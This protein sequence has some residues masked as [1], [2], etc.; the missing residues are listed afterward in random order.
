MLCENPRFYDNNGVQTSKLHLKQ[1][2]WPG[3]P[4]MKTRRRLATWIF[5]STD[6]HGRQRT[7]AS[8]EKVKLAVTPGRDRVRAAKMWGGL[9]IGLC[10]CFCLHVC[11]ALNALVVGA[12]PCSAPLCGSNVVTRS[13]DMDTGAGSEPVQQIPKQIWMFWHDGFEN[14]KEEARLSHMSW[15]RMNPTY[16][17]HALNSSEAERL[18]ERSK[19]V[20][21]EVWRRLR[22]QHKADI[23]RTLLVH[24]YGGVWADA[25]TFCGQPLDTWLPKLN[26][27]D[28]IT[29]LRSDDPDQQE[30]LDIAPWPTNW[31]LAAQ[32]GSYTIGR[33]VDIIADPSEQHRFF[34]EYFW[35]HRAFSELGR[36]DARIQAQ[37]MTYLSGNPMHCRAYRFWEAAP[38]FKR[39]NWIGERGMLPAF[40]IALKL[41]Y[42]CCDSNL[43]HRAH[44]HVSTSELK[45][46]CAELDCQ[47]LGP[48]LG[49]LLADSAPTT[50]K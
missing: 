24:K 9:E 38:L 4:P 36:A 20:S 34:R 25:S 31:F 44:E 32:A 21:D 43:T 30:R 23:F 28:L 2:S 46:Q 1:P 26:Q 41:H 35:W 39:C 50:K 27:G 47:R 19:Y 17:V 49:T 10:V 3:C 15:R 8:S 33:M 22:I 5:I 18:T 6:S 11:F 40:Q 48:T 14:A 12:E 16:E 29:F 37:S 7:A 13:L 42:A 45:S